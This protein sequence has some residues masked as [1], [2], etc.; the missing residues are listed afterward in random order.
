MSQRQEW[1]TA[2]VHSHPHGAGRTLEV[3]VGDQR[4]GGIET[5]RGPVLCQMPT[6]TFRSRDRAPR[7]HLVRRGPVRRCFDAGTKRDS[8]GDASRSHIGRAVAGARCR[9]SFHRVGSHQAETEFRKAMELAPNEAVGFSW[10]ARRSR[11]L[12][13]RSDCAAIERLL[14]GFFDR[15]D[16]AWSP[17]SRIRAGLASISPRST[18]ATTSSAPIRVSNTP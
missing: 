6:H 5:V 13:R 14:S 15:A 8:R 1:N 18:R 16:R 11:R 7:A 9:E 2:S 12:A 17:E 3:L 10:Y 4:A